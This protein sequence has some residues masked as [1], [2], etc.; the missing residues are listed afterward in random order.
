MNSEYLHL[1]IADRAKRLEILKFFRSKGFTFPWSS[2]KQRD[3]YCDYAYLVKETESGRITVD[4]TYFVSDVTYI[5]T[6]VTVGGGAFSHTK[7]YTQADFFEPLLDNYQEIYYK[8]EYVYEQ[9]IELKKRIV[10]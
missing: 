8:L 10:R 2:N 1:E 7:V 5:D 4:I 3:Y 6:H 9:L